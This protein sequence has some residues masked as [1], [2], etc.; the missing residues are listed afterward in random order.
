MP[1]I[2]RRPRATA[3]RACSIVARRYAVCQ[4]AGAAASRDSQSSPMTYDA[5]ASAAVASGNAPVSRSTCHGR[6]SGP[7]VASGNGTPAS[8][9]HSVPTAWRRRRSSAPHPD[10]VA[11]IDD[12]GRRAVALRRAMPVVEFR[13]RCQLVDRGTDS[14]NGVGP[15]ARRGNAPRRPTTG[16]T[17]RSSSTRPVAA[18]TRARTGCGASPAWISA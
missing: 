1:R 4:V 13:R 8:S 6:C 2:P 16:R 11:S 3:P 10:P 15:L 5:G 9:N 17:P 12:G 18:S 7:S 14:G